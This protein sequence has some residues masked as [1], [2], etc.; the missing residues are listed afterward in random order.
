MMSRRTLDSARLASNLAE[1]FILKNTE[2]IVDTEASVVLEQVE[3]LSYGRGNVEERLE[4]GVG[5]RQPFYKVVKFR[6]DSILTAVPDDTGA[7]RLVALKKPKYMVNKRYFRDE[8]MRQC[9]TN[10]PFIHD[11]E[12]QPLSEIERDDA[13][14][15]VLERAEIAL[16]CESDFY[17]LLN[18][19]LVQCMDS[20]KLSQ[21][22]TQAKALEL[23]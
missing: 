2:V 22:T 20:E 1:Y 8:F 4:I 11:T 23:I 3:S 14:E 19:A 12:V 10:K 21:F 18:L 17:Q 15:A 9:L 6:D 5:D 13:V 7:N 16:G